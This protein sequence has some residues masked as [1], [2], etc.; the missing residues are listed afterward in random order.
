M[1]FNLLRPVVFTNLKVNEVL[2]VYS[3]LDPVVAYKG[4]NFAVL[5]FKDGS[6]GTFGIFQLETIYKLTPLCW[7]EEKPVYPGDGPLYFKDDPTWRHNEEGGVF[8]SQLFIATFTFSISR[9][10]SSLRS[11]KPSFGSYGPCQTPWSQPTRSV[12]HEK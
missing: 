10:I 7:V 9:Y 4:P 5:R 2:K 8:A 12:S 1:N 3:G 6:E 11:I